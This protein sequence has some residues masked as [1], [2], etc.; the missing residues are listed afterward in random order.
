[1]FTF[2]ITLTLNLLEFLKFTTPHEEYIFEN[3]VC[4][5]VLVSAFKEAR[6]IVSDAWK[7]TKSE[8]IT[9][10]HLYTTYVALRTVVNV[11]RRSTAQKL[12]HTCYVHKYI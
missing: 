5:L 7:Q 2:L 11:K 9:L 1:M 8:N 6:S 3:Y 10:V 12:I 4:L